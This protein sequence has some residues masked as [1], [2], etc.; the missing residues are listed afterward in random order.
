MKE[1]QVRVG[2]GVFVFN[3][4]E[5]LM[6]QRQG[7]HGAGT[8]A[9]PGGKLEYG[10]TFEEVAQREVR[11]ETGLKIA[12]VA[13]AGVTN[14]LFPDG[15]HYVTLWLTSHYAGGEAK[16]NEPEKCADMRWCTF[17]DLP[18]PLFMSFQNLLSTDFVD[19]IRTQ[20][21]LSRR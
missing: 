8:W 19:D 17:N 11:E 2:A 13:L 7:A 18:S 20:A 6:M 10:E 12:N 1:K 9:P 14:D 21:D 3:D 5:F 16:I 4:G 15:G